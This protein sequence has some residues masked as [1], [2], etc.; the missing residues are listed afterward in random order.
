MSLMRWPISSRLSTSR[1]RHIRFMDPKA[2]VRTG[3]ADPLTRSNS[4]ALFCRSLFLRYPVRD[5]GDL[6]L[7]IHLG[8]DPDQFAVLFEN[9]YKIP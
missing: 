2:L 1:A 4:R 5:L 9:S 7:G 3:K 6:K 8:L